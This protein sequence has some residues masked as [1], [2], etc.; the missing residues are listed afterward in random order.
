MLSSKKRFKAPRKGRL[1][2]SRI[3]VQKRSNSKAVIFQSVRCG[4]LT[5]RQIETL[6]RLIRRESKKIGKLWVQ[7]V[8]DIPRTK[9]AEKTR[10]GKG[11]G[12]LNL[13]VC[14]VYPG[15]SLFEVRGFP[16]SNI[17]SV[18]KKINYKIPLKVRAV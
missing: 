13:W 8:A 12:R 11:K 1:S 10:M 4:F 3:K 6:R 18:V 17:K 9:K 5:S 15:K 2:N 14:K 7:A 16:I